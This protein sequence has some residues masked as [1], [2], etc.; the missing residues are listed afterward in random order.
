M[1]LVAPELLLAALASLLAR[2]GLVDVAVAAGGEVR[3]VGPVDVLE[4]GVAREL[5]ELINGSLA[6]A[7][8]MLVINDN[9]II[10]LSHH[11]FVLVLD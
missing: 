6:L 4:L 1:I 11:Y 3:D 5:L 2:C 7:A 8:S 9:S 10:T